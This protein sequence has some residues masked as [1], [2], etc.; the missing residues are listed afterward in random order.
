MPGPAEWSFAGVRAMARAP[1][2]LPFK[3]SLL[4]IFT[5]IQK[6][7]GFYFFVH[8]FAGVCVAQSYRLPS[9]GGA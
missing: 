4:S 3:K 2:A 9:A 1:A 7:L 5:K 6:K 8:I